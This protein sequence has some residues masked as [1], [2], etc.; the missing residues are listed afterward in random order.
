MPSADELLPILAAY[1]YSAGCALRPLAGGLINQTFVVEEAGRRTVLQRLHEIFAPEVHLDIEPI[2]AHL[3]RK[4]VRT[5]RL[6]PTTTG[7][8]WTTD[9]QGHVWRMLTWVEGRTVHAIERVETARAAGCFVARFHE[10]VSDL[11]H[12]F[13]F[14]RPGAHDTR[15]HLAALRDA[16]E[17]HAGH[18]SYAQVAPVA[19]RILAHA[20]GLEPLPLV[21][22]R[23]V[24]G[25]L[26]VSNLL[27][28]AQAD[29]ALALLD[30]D[31]MAHLTIPIELGDALRS[32]CNP[33]GE[34]AEQASFRGDVF[35]ASV[36]GYA[37][38]ARALLT[39]EEVA[40]LVP[41]AETI[42]LELAARFCADALRERYFGWNPEKFPSRSAHN[43]VRAESQLAVAESVRAQRAELGDI[44]R[45]QFA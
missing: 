25:D 29:E 8:L 4:G 11:E 7:D 18:A 6:I 13:H 45:R 14:T 39:A 9:A 40:S 28:N 35:E 1:G 41:A 20:E 24:H 34:D 31:T 27:F 26:K 21:P 23:V 17:K 3:E 15:M 30:L 42:A 37:E 10:A 12:T 19:E 32:W 22:T 36:A 43:L 33:A 5:P 44:V 2:T 16:L 38:G